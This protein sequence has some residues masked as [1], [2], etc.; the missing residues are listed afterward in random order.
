MSHPSTTLV[1]RDAELTELAS[2]LGVR[3]SDGGIVLLS[4]D[5]GVGK[6]RLLLELRDLALA[7]G[8]Q[9]VAGHCLDFGDSALPYLPFSEVLGR[10]ATDLGDVVGSVAAAHPALARLQ[11]GR[12]VLSAAV[13]GEGPSLDR[14]DLFGA[15]HALLEAAAERCPLLLVIEDMHWADRSTRDMLGFL[16]SR[17]FDAPVAIVASYRSDDLHRRHPLR[18]QVAEWSRLRGVDRMALAPLADDAV[19]ALVGQLVPAGLSERELADIV[20][21]AEGNAFFVEE[22]TS[23]AAQPGSWVPADLADVLLV[24][25]D[26]LDESAR[27]VVRA[28]SA[29]GRKVAH[30]MLEAASGLD[31]EALEEGLRG[32]VEM[33]VLVAE[34]GRYA[35]RHALLGEAVYDDLLPGE[36]VRLHRQYAVALSE[37]RARGTAAELA[38]HA[39]LANDLDTALSASI[40]AGNEASTVG[41]PDEAAYHFQQALELLADPARHADADLDLS[42]L[43][44]ATADALTASGDPERAV[45]VIQEQLDR[46]P[47]D[48]GAAGRARMLSAQANALY[49]TESE[50]DPT[51]LSARAVELAPE[52]ESPLR[53]RVLATHARILAAS[54]RYAEAQA[55]GMDALGLAERLDLHELASDA[56]T[57]LGGLKKAGPKEGLRAALDEA[58][59]RA[60]EAGAVHAE[61]RGR[62]FLGR[63]F[64][65]WAEFDDSVAWFASAIER[66]AEA[67]LPWA[68]YAFESRYQLA[69]VHLIRG[70]WD[71]VLRLTEVLDPHPPPIPQGM[72]LTERL[73]VQQARG[74]DVAAEAARLRPLWSREG[75]VAIHAAALEM[76]A[77]ARRADP[78]AVLAVYDDVVEVLSR[79]WRGWFSARI[80]LAAVAVAGVAAALPRLSAVER[81]RYAA[82]VDRLAEDGRTVL[83][84]YTDPSG[85]WGPEGRAWVKRL[86]AEALRAHWL[87]GVDPPPQETLVETWREAVALFDAFGHVHERTAC[88]VALAGI[89]RAAGDPAGA[90]EVGDLA[91]Q[92]AHAL[93]A[94]PLLDELRALGGVPQRTESVPDALTAREREILALVADGRSNGEIAKLLFISAKT[95]SVHV[96]N[97]LGKLGAAGRTEAAAIAR[98]RGLL[99]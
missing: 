50:Q 8:W 22:L 38:R 53:A 10:L 52:G 33:N 31:A 93:G 42:K 6:T 7:E 68:P 25:L 76:V 85:H 84:R 4:G 57:T 72:L 2:S 87:A 44:V 27:Q 60:Q 45:A 37:G 98:R 63:S 21:R 15:V 32:A 41:G 86:E 39:R 77:A 69:M 26:R 70:E 23:A 90:R 96:S 59:V 51:A 11:P 47:A 9:V 74:A 71:E 89:L 49:I 3:A 61:L 35:F 36:R 94:Q 75:S 81:E 13:A 65:D 66:A 99:D 17:P 97:I 34:H 16:F 79:I 46:L 55:V 43:V 67:G 78:A 54:G 83:D 28:A 30:D 29:S 18:R 62:F 12:R 40:R 19:R 80:R 64:Q 91:R 1:G 20:D 92:T 82:R 48:A 95:V 73:H 88:Q 24:R 58:V 5:A 56:I 14:A